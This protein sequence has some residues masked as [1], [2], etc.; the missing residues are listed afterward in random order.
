VA[1]PL[2]GVVGASIAHIVLNT[3]WLACAVILFGRRIRHEIAQP[4][5]ARLAE[6]QG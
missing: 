5:D 2:L 4:E 6:A 1:L 3:L